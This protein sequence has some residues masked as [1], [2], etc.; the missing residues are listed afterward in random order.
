[1]HASGITRAL[2]SVLFVGLLGLLSS[3]C[4][5]DDAQF[6]SPGTGLPA[7]GSGDYPP[8]MPSGLHVAKATS[9]GFQLTW[10]ANTEEDLAG[11]L[12]YVYDPDPW[13]ANSYVCCHEGATIAASKTTYLYTADLSQGPHYFK[14]AAVDLD[15]NESARYGPVQFD[16]SAQTNDQRQQGASSEDWPSPLPPSGGVDEGSSSGRNESGYPDNGRP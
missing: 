2:L 16:Y 14:I 10:D 8:A 6:T 5:S 13:R 15:G 12:I 4:S 1:M 3:G 7:S 9:H 11:Y